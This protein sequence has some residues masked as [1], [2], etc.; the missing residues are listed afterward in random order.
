[1]KMDRA[2]AERRGATM[3]LTIGIALLALIAGVAIGVTATRLMMPAPKLRIAPGDMS[4]VLG[5]LDLTEEQREQASEILERSAPR[6][7]A[8]MMEMAGR[9]RGVADSVD[10]ELRRILT[11]EQRVRLDSLRGEPRLILRRTRVTP[12]GTQ[13]DTI[14]DTVMSRDTR[15]VSPRQ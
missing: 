1:M 4:A 8:I 6:S 15:R 5:R 7:R 14:V 11:A 3:K 9:L 10:D 2:A 13:T 12:S